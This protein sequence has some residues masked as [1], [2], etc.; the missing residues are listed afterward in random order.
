MQVHYSNVRRRRFAAIVA[1]ALIVRMRRRQR[2]RRRRQ[3]RCRRSSSALKRIAYDG[4]SDDLLTGGPRQDRA[5]LRHGAGR[6]ERHRAHDR[7]AAQAR[8]LQQLPRARRRH[9]ARRL[10]RAVRPEHRSQRRGHAGRRQDRRRRVSRLCRRRHRA[11]ER[12]ADGADPDQLGPQP[13]VHRHGTSSGSR[14]VYG[15]IGTAGEWGLKRGC[16]VAYA[17]KG[18]GMGVHDLATDTVN[19]QQGHARDRG[20]RGQGLELHVA[21]RQ[22]AHVVQRRASEPDRRQARAFAAEPR[23]GLGH[24]TR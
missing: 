24:A 11:E 15:A 9:R 1:A 21:D 17:D 6:R 14:G 22:R 19:L 7:R 23:A 16:A 18:T 8:D 20:G 10:R 2:R 12:H 13:A 3:R 4:N 5:R